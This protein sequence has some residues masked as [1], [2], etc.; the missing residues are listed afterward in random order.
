MR[1]PGG[2]AA[3]D[4]ML[5]AVPL[6]GPLFDKLYQSRSFRSVGTLIDAGVPLSDVL[7]LARD[8]SANHCYRELWTA[9]HTAVT[10]GEHLATPMADF[11]FIPEPV[12]EMI[13]C[14]DRTGRLG[15]VFVSLGEFI[16][17]EY[18]RA[19]KTMCQLLEP[20]MIFVMGGI[21]GM[22]ALA[23]LLPLFGAASVAAR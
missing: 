21:V 23:L 5:L 2:R 9:V 7:V 11:P 19:M 20:I 14:G 17:E 15:Q 4:R 18:D 13:N 16:E 3:R 1:T 22:V 12:R 6:L 8:M 10:N